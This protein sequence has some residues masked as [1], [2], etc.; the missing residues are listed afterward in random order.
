MNQQAKVSVDAIR[1]K[2]S[3]NV[4]TQWVIVFGSQ[5]RGDQRPDSDLD[6]LH[7]VRKGCDKNNDIHHRAIKDAVDGAAGGVKDVTIL[8]ETPI[9]IQKYGN[10]YG[11]TEY[12]ALREGVAVYESKNA[13]HIHTYEMS[14]A[15]NARR[16]LSRAYMHILYGRQLAKYKRPSA[17]SGR[18]TMWNLSVGDSL[19]SVLCSRGVKFPFTRDDLRRL[20]G[21]LPDGAGDVLGFDTGMLEHP[22]ERDAERAY[23]AAL[24]WLGDGV[25]ESFAVDDGPW[26]VLE[27]PTRIAELEVLRA[28]P[29]D[30]IHSVLDEHYKILRRR[31][32]MLTKIADGVAVEAAR[33]GGGRG[34]KSAGGS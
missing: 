4:D 29:A 3:K 19:R 5:A 6:I 16:W 20:H 18:D 2:V 12:N 34:G 21:W 1:E 10:L 22:G 25:P 28:V 23:S 14:N 15:E 11:S 8:V 7:I 26:D 17:R 32:E 13:Q 9:T 31:Y 33:G 30:R 24:T 27:L